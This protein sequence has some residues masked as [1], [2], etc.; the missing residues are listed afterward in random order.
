MSTLQEIIPSIFIPHIPDLRPPPS[1]PSTAR[2]APLA[3]PPRH[4][5]PY[6]ILHVPTLAES[7]M[8]R[9]RIYLTTA[10][11]GSIPPS[12]QLQ[13]CIDNLPD[14]LRDTSFGELSSEETVNELWGFYLFPLIRYAVQDVDQNPTRP[15][16]IV[17][18]T[19]YSQTP[20]ALICPTS[21]SS[22]CLHYEG[23]SWMVFNAFAPKILA[24]AQHVEDGRVGTSLELRINEEGARSIIMK[25]GVSMI[26]RANKVPYGVLFGGH[27]FI[28][29]SLFCNADTL[30]EVRYGL[31]CSDIIDCTKISTP[32]IPLII[33]T[34]LGNANGPVQLCQPTF[35]IPPVPTPAI[36]DSKPVTR[37]RLKKFV[38]SH[39]PAKVIF[40]MCTPRDAVS[41][42][43][44]L[45]REPDASESVAAPVRFLGALTTPILS[46]WPF[47]STLSKTPSNAQ[48]QQTVE[49][50]FA[51]NA[52]LVPFNEIELSLTECVGHGASGQVFVG[53]TDDE[54]YAIKIA[55]WK[56]GKQMLRREADIYQILSDLQGQCIPKI[57]GFY[58]SADL[59][60]LIM[61]YM[62]CS[63]GKIS[64]LSM[65]QRHQLLDELCL[66]HERGVVHGD[67]RAPNIVLQNGSAHFIDF[68][69]GYEHQCTGRAACSE[70]IQAR[71]F[72]LLDLE[73]P[74]RTGQ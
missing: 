9:L 40:H 46:I 16:K 30:G 57:Y 12:R 34:L 17:R 66:I 19:L 35:T 14:N 58:R 28:L 59:A 65:D 52:S 20:D 25:L 64:D 10:P 61:A 47:S 70:L 48:I 26:G 62:G 63:V 8:E 45:Y 39:L 21:S 60:A 53:E 69:H 22:P 33:Y 32:F 6:W 74:I 29:F 42:S 49:D 24:L 54:K 36:Q 51:S 73:H 11:G 7:T 50:P 38:S 1:A 43:F 13:Q 55:P 44:V 37:S 31:A 5:V 41:R 23:K 68:S 71:R 2:Y 72:L 56:N 15:A 3:A 67:L 18:S 27:R 4:H